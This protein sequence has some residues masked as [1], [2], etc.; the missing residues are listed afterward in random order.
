MKSSHSFQQFFTQGCYWFVVYVA[1]WLLLSAGSDWGFGLA[2]ASA[3]TLLSLWLKLPPLGLRLVYLPRFLLFFVYETVLG[4]WDV[5]RR[6][7]HPNLPLDPGWVT[8]PLRCPNHR[9]RLLL[10]A[11]VGLMPGTLSS[12]F[13]GEN[14]YLHVLDQGQD[15]RTTVTRMETHLAHLLGGVPT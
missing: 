3:A 7:L 5:A 1:L 11:M 2:F 15:W 4:A 10:S 13:D 9:V 8:Y 12:H 14:L 6:A